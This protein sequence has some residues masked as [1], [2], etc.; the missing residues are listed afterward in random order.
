MMPAPCIRKYKKERLSASLF[1]L[2]IIKP[3]AGPFLAP[4]RK[5]R[6]HRDQLSIERGRVKTLPTIIVL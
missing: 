2:L 6:P 5:Y 3:P 1:Y 4:P